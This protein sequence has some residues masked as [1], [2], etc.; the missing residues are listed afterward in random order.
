MTPHGRAPTISE[1]ILE[2]ILRVVEILLA[3]IEVP[4]QT[5]NQI[6]SALDG[7]FGSGLT[8]KARGTS[9]AVG[10]GENLL[11]RGRGGPTE[12]ILIRN[13]AASVRGAT[14]TAAED[15][16]HLPDFARGHR[17]RGRGRNGNVGRGRALVLVLACRGRG[18]LEDGGRG[19]L[20]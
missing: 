17:R 3:E 18:R 2:L 12:S 15:A 7:K 16:P 1:S 5:A 6:K 19:P 13:P 11:A 9:V 8:T 10:N 20:Y 14:D 4:R